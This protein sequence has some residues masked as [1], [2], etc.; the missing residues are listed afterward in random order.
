MINTNHLLKVATYWVSIVYAV[1]YLGVLL[2]PSIR[3]TFM[4][5]ALHTKG[6]LGT[7][8][9]TLSTF[10]SGLVIWNIVALLGV[11][12]FAFLFNSTKQ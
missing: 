10:I 8:V 7:D 9:L 3:E 4:L 12:L 2:F 5:Y 1:C 6:S 11:W